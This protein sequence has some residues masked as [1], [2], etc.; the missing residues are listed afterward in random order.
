MRLQKSEKAR[1]RTTVI[2]DEVQKIPELLN[3]VHSL[4]EEFPNSQFILTGSSARKLKQS[5]VNLLAGRA[6]SKRMYPFILPELLNSNE[7]TDLDFLLQSEGL[8][9]NL[10]Q[11]SHFLDVAAQGFTEVINYSKIGRDCGQ[12]PKTTQNYFEILED[13]LIGFRM[14]FW[15]ESKRQQLA[16]HPKFY[17]FD[18]G[19]TCA[20]LSRLVDPLD[21]PLRGRLFEQW[22]INNA[23]ARTDYDERDIQYYAWRNLSNT[24]EVDLFAVRGKTP[25][26]GA[27]IKSFSQPTTEHL[28]GLRVLR[29]Q[30]PKLPLYLVCTAEHPYWV[31]DVEQVLVVPWQSFLLE[32]LPKY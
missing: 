20:L 32:E 13:T 7:M 22:L 11:F 12:S 16:G 28:D 3:E 14:M 19:V 8:T 10:P 9:R 2:I 4:I 27:E 26:F 15:S 21:T 5:S 31:S 17:F 23:R 24:I 25:L 1:A 30:Y 29:E 6:I 18:N